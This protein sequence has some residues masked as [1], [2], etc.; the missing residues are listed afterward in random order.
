MPG[1]ELV[2]EDCVRR[3]AHGS[4]IQLSSGKI[5]TPAAL[6]LAHSRGIR[7]EQLDGSAIPAAR[8]AGA[9]QPSGSTWERMKASDGTFI[10][11][12]E[13]GRVTVTRLGEDGPTPFAT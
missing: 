7:V 8:S 2:T 13:G 1:K 10:V 5:A 6:D 3:M 11:Q 4:V 12:V 9:A